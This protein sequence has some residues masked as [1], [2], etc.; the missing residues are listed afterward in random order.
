MVRGTMPGLA[1][2]GAI[3]IPDA[4][5]APPMAPAYGRKH[6]WTEDN[7]AFAAGD[8]REALPPS[9]VEG[10]ARDAARAER[11]VER[12]GVRLLPP[13]SDDAGQERLYGPLRGWS[14]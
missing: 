7:P 13:G 8:P 2:Q 6:H 9:T 11:G 14:D 1:I 4:V 5:T 12:P 10:L 3:K